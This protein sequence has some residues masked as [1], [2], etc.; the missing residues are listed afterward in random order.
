MEITPHTSTKISKPYYQQNCAR[1]KVHNKILEWQPQKFQLSSAQLLQQT[2]QELQF[3]PSLSKGSFVWD[4]FRINSTAALADKPFIQKDNPFKSLGLTSNLSRCHKY[5]S[6]PFFLGYPEWLNRCRGWRRNKV[7][8]LWLIFR[9]CAICPKQRNK[10]EKI[11]TKYPIAMS[12]ELVSPDYTDLEFIRA[13]FQEVHHGI[14]N[15][16]NTW[17]FRG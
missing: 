7:K 4:S 17:G 11:S 15:C 5:L 8:V 14:T 13:E 16:P 12:A 2:S 3:K 10:L 6:W 1:V 9:N